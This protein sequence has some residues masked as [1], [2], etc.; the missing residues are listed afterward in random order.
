MSNMRRCSRGLHIYDADRHTVCPECE[1]LKIPKGDHW[2]SPDD[3]T[4][5]IDRTGSD[6]DSP[7]KA[8]SEDRNAKPENRNDSTHTQVVRTSSGYRPVAGWLVVVE[9]PGKGRSFSL[10]P[11]VNSIGRSKTTGEGAQQREQE[12]SLDFGPKSDLE[13]AREGQAKLT[14]ADKTNAFY[15]QHGGGNN[16]T[17]L[18]DQPVLEVKALSPYDQIAMGKTTLVFVPFCG[19]KF[20][21]PKE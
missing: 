18:N 4:L 9:G 11:G 5:K 14:Y 15:I 19:D 20:S 3:P 21:W 7:K 17:Y 2:K 6:E 8:P 12:V 16:L 13:I 1:T 10:Y